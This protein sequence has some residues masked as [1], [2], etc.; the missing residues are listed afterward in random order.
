MED[1]HINL[2]ISKLSTTISMI[3]NNK[4]NI[5]MAIFAVVILHRILKT[6]NHHLQFP[7]FKASKPIYCA[8]CLHDVEK[9]QRYRRLPQCRH[10]FHVTCVD[11]WLQ[12]RSTCPLCRNQIP[13]HLLPRKQEKEPSFWYLFVYFS[14]KAIKVKLESSLNKMMLF[15]VGGIIGL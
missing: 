2:V 4:S 12:S 7:T 3:L 6:I 10:C 9:G 13:I 8:V 11:T 15:E 14:V 1:D 5:F